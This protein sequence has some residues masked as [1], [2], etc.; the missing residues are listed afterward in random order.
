MPNLDRADVTCVRNEAL[1]PLQLHIRSG[2]LHGK[3]LRDATR[4]TP[5]SAIPLSC[6]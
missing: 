4:T 6:R 5:S 1:P 3:P 2:R